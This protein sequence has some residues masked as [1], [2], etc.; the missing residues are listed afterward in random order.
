MFFGTWTP[1]GGWP[2]L[3]WSFRSWSKLLLE[4]IL[5]CPKVLIYLDYVLTD[6]IF[7]IQ[8][9][10][11]IIFTLL[12]L[13]S[14]PVPVLDTFSFIFE[15]LFVL[16]AVNKFWNFV[17]CVSCALEFILLSI[18]SSACINSLFKSKVIF[19]RVSFF[20]QML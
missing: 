17:L 13:I 20:S 1:F 19:F 5:L 11:F 9:F 7:F 2:F 14:L 3:A 8:V 12:F 6:I 15:C 16:W 4:W 18:Y 10:F